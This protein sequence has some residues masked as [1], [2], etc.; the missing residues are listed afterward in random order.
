MSTHGFSY[1]V[2]GSEEVRIS[3]HGRRAV[4]LRG[5]VAARFLVDVEQHDPQQR[6]RASR[7]TTSAATSAR[8]GPTL[9]AV[10]AEASLP[11]DRHSPMTLDVMTTK[12]PASR[13]VRS[14][15]GEILLP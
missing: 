5:A 9:A 7:A 11:H 2:R 12:A 3:H 10:A 6:W 14:R 8:P 15:A 1:V 13:G 4:I